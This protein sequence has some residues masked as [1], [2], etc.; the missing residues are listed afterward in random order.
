MIYNACMQLI[1]RMRMKNTRIIST[2][3]L[4]HI[5]REVMFVNLLPHLCL[6]GSRCE[7]LATYPADGEEEVQPV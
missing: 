3:V 4:P 2:K 5:K 7:A 6:E 1:I